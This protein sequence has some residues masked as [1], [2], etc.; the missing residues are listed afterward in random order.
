MKNKFFATK[1]SNLIVFSRFLFSLARRSFDEG[2]KKETL[3]SLLPNRIR[4]NPYDS[5]ELI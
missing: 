2:G 3:R 5:N 1:P 4:A